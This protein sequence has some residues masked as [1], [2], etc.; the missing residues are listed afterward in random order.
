M[1]IYTAEE[2]DLAM[3]LEND[4][5]IS[6]DELKISIIL[7]RVYIA[8]SAGEEPELIGWL[9]YNLFWDS[10]PFLN[11]LYIQNDQ[12]RK[13]Y[14]TKLVGY[15]EDQMR[16]IHHH[17]VMTSTAQNEY[18]QHFY[19]KLGYKAVGSFMPKDGPLEIIFQ[20]DL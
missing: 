6:E 4:T 20:K 18:A 5:H 19:E 11:M 14:G 1:Q 2:K 15:W 8:N 12:K 13:G 10:I 9:R 3:L 17:S 7:K 16:Q